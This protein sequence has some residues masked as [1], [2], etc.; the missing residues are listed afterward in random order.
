MLAAV[1]FEFDLEQGLAGDRHDGA[2]AHFDF[3]RKIEQKVAVGTDQP[4]GVFG[5][6]QVAREPVKIISHA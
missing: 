2:P 4:G 3:A 1:G 5:A 6:A